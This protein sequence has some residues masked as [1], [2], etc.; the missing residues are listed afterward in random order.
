[1]TQPTLTTAAIIGCAGLMPAD[2]SAIVRRRRRY[3]EGPSNGETLC[4]DAMERVLASKEMPMTSRDAFRRAIERHD[5]DELIA[6]FRED[7]VLHSPITFQPF[8]A[9]RRSGACSRSSSR[10]SKAFTTPTSSTPPT[11]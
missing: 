8:E 2:T 1:M 3:D 10:S 4:N 11:A 6:L 7:A 9:R 5:F